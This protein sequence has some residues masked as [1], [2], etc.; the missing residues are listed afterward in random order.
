MIANHYE[1]IATI[2]VGDLSITSIDSPMEF[3]PFN[4]DIYVANEGS[5]TVS[6]INSTTNTVT[7]TIDVGLA[8]FEPEFNYF[9]NKMYILNRGD[10]TVSVIDSL[11]I[12]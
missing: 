4:N 10:G 12:Q 8:P 9:D 2:P 7:K 5:N 11:Q 3:N 6:V 1:V